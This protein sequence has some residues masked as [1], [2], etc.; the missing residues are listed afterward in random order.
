MLTLS[1]AIGPYVESIGAIIKLRKIAPEYVLWN[2]WPLAN[3][4][5]NES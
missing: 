5:I 2:S 3:V 1:L 4:T